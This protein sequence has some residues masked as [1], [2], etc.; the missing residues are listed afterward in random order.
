MTNIIY[1]Y[2]LINFH[3]IYVQ[4]YELLRNLQQLMNPERLCIQMDH[5]IHKG[6]AMFH[7]CEKTN[8]LCFVSRWQFKSL[9]SL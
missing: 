2:L 1:W 6:Q 3:F 5:N 4:F 9:P 7:R 8:F